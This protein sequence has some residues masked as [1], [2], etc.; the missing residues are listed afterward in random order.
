MKNKKLLFEHEEKGV[1]NSNPE[2]IDSGCI[3][4]RCWSFKILHTISNLGETK[5]EGEGK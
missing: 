5:Y 4:S 3:G 1:G 2:H